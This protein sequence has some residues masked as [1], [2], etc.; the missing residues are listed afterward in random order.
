MTSMAGRAAAVLAATG[1]SLGAF[2]TVASVKPAASAEVASGCRWMNTHSSP[3][4]RAQE[5]LQAMT[6]PE[7]IAMVHGSP[8][9]AGAATIGAAGYVPG[10]ATLCIPELVLN[11]AGAGVAD[12]QP[13]TT[14]FPAP[15]AQTASWDP[16]LQSRFG[17]VLGSEA[18][19]KGI[20]VMLGPAIN[21]ARVPMDGRNFEY[22]GEDPF[23]A[24]QTA[25][26]EI[27]GI[28]KNPVIATVKHFAANNQET[29]RGTVSAEVDQRTLHEIYLPAFQAAV[30]IGHTG[31]VM[32]SYNQ[33]NDVYACQNPT[34]L[35]S[36]LK[37]EWSFEGFVM[38]DWLATHSTHQ[39][40]MAGLDMEMPGA[41]FFGPSLQA[42]IE[43]GQVPMSQLDDMVRRILTS[44]FRLGLFDHPPREGASVAAADV[45]TAS[46]SRL[47]LEVSEAGTV[48]LKNAGSVLPLAGNHRTLAVIGG[49]AGQAG[50]ES[51]YG[52]GGSSHVPAYTD[53]PVVAPLDGIENL[54]RSRGDRVVSDVGTD[55]AGAAE[56]AKGADVAIVF[57]SD[58][59]GESFDRPGLK[60]QSGDC[61]LTC[62]YSSSDQ[63]LLIGSVARAN[64]HTVVVLD[65]GGPVL[66]PW[67]NQVQ[68][69]LE[70]WYPGQQ[71]GNAIASILFGS[72]DPSGKLPQTFPA[73]EDQ[74]PTATPQ[75]YPGVNG[76]AVYSEGLLVGYR[77][78]DTKDIA[79]L[80]PFGFGLSYTHFAFSGLSVKPRS[81]GADVSFVV[82]NTGPRAGAEVAQ[83]YLG[84]PRS[85]GEPPK[86][87]EGYSKVTLAAGQSKKVS[88][89]LGQRGFSYWDVS[90]QGWTVAPG[91]YAVMAGGSSRWL[92]LKGRL[93]RGGSTCAR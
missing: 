32:C 57:A 69:V 18:W 82:R 55:P 49:P 58:A 21:I 20:N 63:D 6:L 27:G 36:I 33:I 48:L 3:T 65:T 29:D 4:A 39:A 88:I 50:A 45:T 42:A 12:G 7:K 87:L 11:D 34:T 77:W 90:K 30:T 10:D 41:T 44:M 35:T 23:L 85:T 60:L 81:N 13:H 56:V 83:V 17:R 71:D 76:R 1:G 9:S 24:G 2:A 19:N 26:S 59:E 67:I 14:A 74:L 64:P 84:D 73:S 51:V 80:F 52:G 25:S 31:A 75:Q 72:V 53:A 93:P 89:S 61:L 68:G 91:C 66:M 38:S 5:L 79:P 16:F 92:P 15:I 8:W 62:S 78:Y 37:D 28:Q 70:A 54:A 47:A 46:D 40:V 22:M 43:D 86:Q